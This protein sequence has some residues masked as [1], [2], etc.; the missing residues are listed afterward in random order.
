MYSRWYNVAVVALWLATMG[1][2]VSQKVLPSLLIGEPPDYQTILA[3][4]MGSPP[5]GWQLLWNDRKRLGWAVT[6]VHPLPNGLTEVRSFVHFSELPLGEIVPDWL[7]GMFQPLDPVGSRL[8]MDARSTLTF[9][10]LQRLS[11]FESAVRFQPK[12][13]AIK[14]WGRIDGAKLQLVIHC[15]DLPPYETEVPAPR[16]TLLSDALSPHGYLPG[17]KEGQRWTEESYGP[18]RPPNSPREILHAT[19]E[20]K[21]PT[22]WNGQVVETLRVVYRSDP[23]SALGS[24]G[25]PRGKLWVRRDGTVLK[26]QV[27]VLRSTM[28]FVRT[29]DEEA[30]RLARKASEDR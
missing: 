10:P 9:D 17:L 21:E 6:S 4:Q 22:T 16:N 25:S 27:T 26:Q 30:E 14:M 7:Q 2:L 11:Q 29:S 13:D 12:V 23:G 19:V 28:T 15:A 5:V 18:L 24:A 8:K 1:W 20:C 3:A